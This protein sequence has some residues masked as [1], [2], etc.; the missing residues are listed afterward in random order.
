MK[1]SNG[2]KVIFRKSIEASYIKIHS[3]W[4]ERDEDYKPVDK[5]EVYGNIADIVEVYYLTAR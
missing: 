3:I 4:D 2:L 1:N 5:S